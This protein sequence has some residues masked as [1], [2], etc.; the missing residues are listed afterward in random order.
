VKAPEP[1]QVLTTITRLAG[2]GY[3]PLYDLLL[4]L[5]GDQRTAQRGLR[6]A[7]S[8]GLVLERRGPDGRRYVAVASD[9]WALLQAA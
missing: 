8:E 3:A 4:E 5:P 1:H 7:A 2:D 6:R 9:G